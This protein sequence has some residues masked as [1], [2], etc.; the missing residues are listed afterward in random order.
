MVAHTKNNLWEREREREASK[1]LLNKNIGLYPGTQGQP[2]LRRS[3]KLGTGNNPHSIFACS[4]LSDPFFSLSTSFFCFPVTYG[5]LTAL[6][7]TYYSSKYMPR[8]T[9]CV[10]IPVP[11]F[12]ERECD[13]PSL[14]QVSTSG[15]I[16]NEQQIKSM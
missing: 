15:P 1:D 2:V 4:L 3:L 12:Q 11:T 6:K 8:L 10:W 7:L 13:W 16:S 9:G 5:C 14:G